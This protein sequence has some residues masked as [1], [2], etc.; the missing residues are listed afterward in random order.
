MDSDKGYYYHVKWE[1][2]STHEDTITD[3]EGEP[4]ENIPSLVRRKKNLPANVKVN[5]SK[6]HVF[7][8]PCPRC[9][10]RESFASIG[11]EERLDKNGS[12]K[13]SRIIDSSQ[14]CSGCGK[15]FRLS[16]TD[17]RVEG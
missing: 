11:M 9:G 16:L 10:K 8:I 7:L 5:Y 15:P 14:T 4:Y 2:G 13:V 1:N 3:D 6:V 12:Y 17:L